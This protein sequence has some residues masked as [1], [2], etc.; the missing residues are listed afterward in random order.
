[1]SEEREQGNRE[2]RALLAQASGALKVFPLPGAVVLP[3]T[4]T[5]FHVFEPRYRA[6]TADALDGDRTLVVATLRR[7]E[8]QAQ[9]RPA[10]HPVAGAGVIEADEKLPDGRYR[11]LFRCLERVRLLEEL[12]NGKPYREFRAEV[13]EDRYPPT[14]ELGLRGSVQAL[15]QLVYDLAKVLPAESGAAKLAEA[16]A[17]MRDPSRLADLVGAAVVSEPAARLEMLETLD[18][19][20]RLELVTQEVASVLL[21]LSRGR[22]ARA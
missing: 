20:R 19:A 13:L 16:A 22:A 21:V 5:P 9:D 3:G 10:L 6:L 11:I 2:L 7:D 14:G 18:V 1:M 8:E 15:E 12:P 17:R 4:P